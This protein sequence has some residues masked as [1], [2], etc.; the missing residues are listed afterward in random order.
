MYALFCLEF[1]SG[2][3]VAK[4]PQSERL[5]NADVM[6]LAPS[7]RNYWILGSVSSIAATL[8]TR[9]DDNGECVWNWASAENSDVY[10]I[11]QS[12]FLKYP[13][14]RPSAT[15]LAVANLKCP[16]VLK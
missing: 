9:N 5:T 10:S 1:S 6:M 12:A 16:G 8:I 2:L 11:V 7:E 14:E 4:E 13:E 3:S 15:I